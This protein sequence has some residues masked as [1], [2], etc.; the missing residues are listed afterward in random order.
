MA[1]AP[2]L[3]LFSSIQIAV[4]LALI[5]GAGRLLGIERKDVLLASN[6]NVG[7]E[8]LAFLLVLGFIRRHNSNT[9]VVLLLARA[10]VK[11]ICNALTGLRPQHEGFM[12]SL[13]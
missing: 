13:E 10:A 7:G 6:A 3:F 12:Q 9:D 2:S 11:M 5:M 1:T 8:L 4:H